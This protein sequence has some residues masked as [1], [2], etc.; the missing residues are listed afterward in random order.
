MR[1]LFLL[2]LTGIFISGCSKNGTKSK[3]PVASAYNNAEAEEWTGIYSTKKSDNA[4]SGRTIAFVD[5][6]TIY[7]MGYAKALENIS[8]TKID[9]VV[10]SY[11]AFLKNKKATAKTVISIDKPDASKN[12]FWAGNPLEEKVKEYNKWVHISET[13]TIPANTDSKSILKLY[14]WNSSKEEILLDDFKVDFY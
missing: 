11:W 10:F 2:T 4:H 8:K 13:F 7:S 14:V 9:S 6:G 12:I 3:E 1:T 5:S